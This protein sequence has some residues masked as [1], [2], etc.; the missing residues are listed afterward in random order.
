[1]LAL[2]QRQLGRAI[3][4]TKPVLHTL[5][6]AH[7]V[8]CWQQNVLFGPTHPIDCPPVRAPDFQGCQT[9]RKASQMDHTHATKRVR[10]FGRTVVEYAY[11]RKRVAPVDGPPIAQ[12]LA[13]VI[14]SRNLDPTEA[15]GVVVGQLCHR[16]ESGDIAI[17]SVNKIA[18]ILGR[19]VGLLNHRG[20]LAV[21][22]VRR[23]D[24]LAFLSAKEW[25]GHDL[26]SPSS[27]TRY[28][29]MWA[30]DHYFKTLRSLGCMSGDPL[31]DI[32]V[33]RTAGLSHRPLTTDEIQQGRAFS[34]FQF[35][36]TRGPSAWAI[37]EATAMTGEINHVYP[38]DV[39]IGNSRVWLGGRANRQARWGLLTDW[40]VVAV[41]KRLDYLATTKPTTK[42][43]VYEGAG[44]E[45][46]KQSAAAGTLGW[47]LRR[48][49]LAADPAVQPKSIPAWA[50]TQVLL[51]TGKIELVA[52]RLGLLTLDAAANF[53]GW[54]WHQPAPNPPSQRNAR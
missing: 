9:S 3:S 26:V 28:N 45:E 12:I 30:L 17:Q 4:F 1:M 14:M 23:G 47:I 33:R 25:K 44:S 19:F 37:A 8:L 40:G 46:S 21:Q 54:D 2:G 7:S 43:L 16:A 50:G 34:Q 29:R 27:A 15:V 11:S 42:Y 52:T 41:R 13:G 32:N 51:E 10:E 31:L 49:G 24:V 48:A 38:D 35:R 6:S 20:V 39:D 18:D 36:D 22:E 53:I 5:H